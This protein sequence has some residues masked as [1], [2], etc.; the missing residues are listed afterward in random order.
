MNRIRDRAKQ[1]VKD[2]SV[3]EKLQAWYPTWCK[4][5]GFHDEYL[6]A[7][8]QDNVSLIDTGGKGLDSLTADSVVVGDQ[9]YP[10]DIIIFGTG[11]RPPFGR[12]SPA[13]KA[14]L[15]IT[16]RNGVDMSQEWAKNGASTLHGV[17]DHNFPN[18]F[19]SGPWQGAV[20]GNYAYMLDTLAQHGAYIL[21]EAK[22]RANVESFAVAPSREAADA[23]R[24]QILMAAPPMAANVGCTPGYFNLEG[25]VDRMSPEKKLVLARSSVLGTGAE[26]FLEKVRAWR[27]T[28]HMPGIDVQT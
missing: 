28:G 27:A 9:S 6:Q 1:I 18:L 17:I 10:V 3:A 24:E 8:N 25:E 19:L 20:C 22:S 12:D 23:W 11:F 26:S 13:E 16:G 14:N 15:T 5:P 4:R 7:F 21:A 2:P